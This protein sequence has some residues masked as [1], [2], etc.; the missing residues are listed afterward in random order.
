[1][2]TQLPEWAKYL[3]A[4]TGTLL[5]LALMWIIA[6]LTN[7]GKNQTEQNVNQ[8]LMGQELRSVSEKVESIHKWRGGQFKEDMKDT[9]ELMMLRREKE[10]H[11]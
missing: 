2:E 3:L 9:I 11:A 1:M 7:I 10:D 8:K 6:A 4:G 5:S